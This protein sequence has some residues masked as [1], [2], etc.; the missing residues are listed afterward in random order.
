MV[1]NYFIHNLP[2][3]LDVLIDDTSNSHGQEGVVPT[4][5]KHDSNAK[6]DSKKWQGPGNAKEKKISIWILNGMELNITYTNSNTVA[7]KFSQKRPK[8]NAKLSNSPVK[9]CKLQQVKGKI[10]WF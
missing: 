4:A 6:Y 2:S 10:V 7:R 8:Q 1:A 5:H 3:V 9:T